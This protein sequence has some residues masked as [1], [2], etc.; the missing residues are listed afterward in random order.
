MQQHGVMAGLGNRQVEARIRRA[1]LRPTRLAA[2]RVTGL[3]GLEGLGQALM[4][5]LG[6]PLRRV[7]SAGALQGMT[8]L[9]QVALGFGVA[10]QQLQQRVAE[11][12]TQF[13]RYIVAAPLATDQQPLGHQLLDRLAQGRP[14]HAELFRQRTLGRQSLARLQGALEDH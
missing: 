8:E 13:G 4:V 6:R 9:Q 5:H 12:G 2:R 1:L 11:G 7:V 3:Q 10:F 14:R